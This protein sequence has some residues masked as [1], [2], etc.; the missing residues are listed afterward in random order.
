MDHGLCLLSLQNL[1]VISTNTIL[2]FDYLQEN[3]EID[4]TMQC[5][6]NNIYVIA[7]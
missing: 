3:F 1:V 7:A 4:K 2:I 5:S 6:W